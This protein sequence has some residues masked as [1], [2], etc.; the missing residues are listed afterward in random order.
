MMKLHINVTG[1]KEFPD[2]FVSFLEKFC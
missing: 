1:R 2:L